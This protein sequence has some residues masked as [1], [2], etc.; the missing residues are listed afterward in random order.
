LDLNWAK[1]CEIFVTYAKVFYLF[2]VRQINETTFE[3]QKYTIFEVKVVLLEIIILYLL[4][5]FFINFEYLI[6]VFGFEYIR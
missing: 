4:A 2:V 1:I 6:L 5:V 3:V